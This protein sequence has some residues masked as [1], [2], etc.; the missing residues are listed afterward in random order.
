MSRSP[1]LQFIWRWPHFTPSEDIGWVR[2]EWYWSIGFGSVT[3]DLAM[4]TIYRWSL[5]LGFLEIR[6]WE[7]DRE[8][9]LVRHRASKG[10]N[11]V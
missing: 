7:I 5:N 10:G 1:K 3:S 6:R 8:Q 11:N 4:S 2:L 9:A